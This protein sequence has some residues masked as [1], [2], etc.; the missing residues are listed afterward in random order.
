[1][2]AKLISNGG[3]S[4]PFSSSTVE[5]D[6]T[7]ELA[8]EDAFTWRLEFLQ[9]PVIFLGNKSFL[10]KESALGFLKWRNLGEEE[11]GKLRYWEWVG[12]AAMDRERREE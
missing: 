8:L 6:S 9:T 3:L 1:M 4:L 2:T 11:M 10:E 12:R 5:K 7:S